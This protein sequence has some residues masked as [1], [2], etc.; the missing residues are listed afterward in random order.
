MSNIIVISIYPT[1]RYQDFLPSVLWVELTTTATPS[2]ARRISSRCFYGIV[3]TPALHSRRTP[4]RCGACVSSGRAGVRFV[5]VPVCPTKPAATHNSYFYSSRPLAPPAE[6]RVGQ[7]S[8]LTTPF[9]TRSLSRS[10]T[11]WHVWKRALRVTRSH[12][13]IF[14]SPTP[15]A[16]PQLCESKNQVTDENTQTAKIVL[17]KRF[18]KKQVQ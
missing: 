7:V 14:N 2:T 4:G 11:S 17:K 1:P 5:Q 18:C 13:L 10:P 8:N 15:S 12:K 6:T 9:S 3:P 16:Q